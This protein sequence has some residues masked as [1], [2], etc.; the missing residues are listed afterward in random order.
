MFSLSAAVSSAFVA[1]RMDKNAFWKLLDGLDAEDAAAELAARLEDLEPAEIAEFQR[2]F[3][4][5]HEAAYIWSLWGAAYLMEGGCSDDGFMDFRYGLISRG[6]KVYEAALADPDTLA[7]LVGDDDFISNEEFGYV[8][9]QVYQSI[10]DEEIPRSDNPPALEPTG[11]EWDF[12][13]MDL[14]AEKLPKLTAKFGD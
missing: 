14:N 6:Q 12:E 1:A 11:E 8:A 10:T 5:A 2:H 7:D 4:E 3:D 13:D 9:G